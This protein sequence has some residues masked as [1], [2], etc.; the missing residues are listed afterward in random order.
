M[1]LNPIYDNEKFPILVQTPFPKI[2]RKISDIMTKNGKIFV[3]LYVTVPKKEAV[4]IKNTTQIF[5]SQ[6]FY[7]L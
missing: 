5:F 4:Y 7:S 3:L 1:S 6:D 2:P